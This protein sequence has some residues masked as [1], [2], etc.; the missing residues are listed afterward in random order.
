MALAEKAR[1][2]ARG[3]R[4]GASKVISDEKLQKALTYLVETDESCARARGLLAGLERQEKTVKALEF[5]K[6]PALKIAE[7]EALAYASARYREHC[8]EISNAMADYEIMRNRRLT[9][10]LIVE[11]WRSENANRRKGNV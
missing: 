6:H 7:R 5:L 1:R 11:V 3:L 4:A 10:E 8:E 2:H 9:A